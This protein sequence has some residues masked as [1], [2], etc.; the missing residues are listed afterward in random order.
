[1][2]DIKQLIYASQHGNEQAKEK[3]V[4][5]NIALVWSL[6][7]RFNNSVYEKE[8]LFQIG[9][10]GL[11]KAINKFDL[12]YDVAFS[13][14]A[15]PIILGEIK[16]HFRD[17][18]AIK[19]SRTLKELNQKINKISEEYLMNNH[20]EI[21]INELST[22]LNVSK[23]DIVLAMDC[24]YYPTSLNEIIYEKDGSTITIEERIE[25]K[26]TY[27]LHDKI[28][29]YDELSKLTKKEQ[30]LIEMRY[31]KDLNQQQIAKHFNVSQVQI[32]RME[33]KIIEK[34]KKQFN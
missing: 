34:L 16:R 21:S 19:V 2:D 11:V 23:E 28:T 7:H 17:D 20:H 9:C 18:G 6:V 5:D 13:T 33:K 1:M 30:E 8:E 12:K 14:Y 27:S 29:L 10:V 32:S 26:E 4:N 24:K 25:D 22:I 15:V 3:L 31:F